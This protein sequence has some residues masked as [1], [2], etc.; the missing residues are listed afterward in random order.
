MKSTEHTENT[1]RTRGIR[2]R[3]QGAKFF[4][5]LC[6]SVCS[7]DTFAGD[8]IRE[9]QVCGPFESRSV[10]T[11]VVEDEGGVS[12]GA[13]VAGKGW[14]GIR[15]DAD[16]VDLE[17]DDALGHHDLSVAFAYAEI[18]AG[19]E[20]DYLLG[21][22]SDDAVIVWWN[23]LP[24]LIHDVLRGTTPGQDKIHVRA[25][26]GKNTLLLKV[27]DEGGGWSF[28]VDQALVSP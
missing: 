18:E 17:R 13:E 19:E 10:L 26:P 16:I 9:W 25:K 5:V 22:G 1:E 2:P 6:I 3:R 23:G 27:Y 20:R 14:K 28:A 15:S 12:P 7:V 11:T 8:F 4:C 24:V 21:I